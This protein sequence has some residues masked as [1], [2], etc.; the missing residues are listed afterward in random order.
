M[1]KHQTRWKGFDDKIMSMCARGITVREIQA[2]LE[3]MYGAEVSPTL[4]ST[5]TDAVMYEAKAWQSHPLD[6]L[7]PIV[8]LDCIHFKSRDAGTVKV[9]VKAVY[10]ALINIAKQWTMPVQNWKPVLNRFTIQFGERMPIT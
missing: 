2:H 1:P 5:V 7:Y 6:A 3:E 8:Y 9:K 10:L 4:I